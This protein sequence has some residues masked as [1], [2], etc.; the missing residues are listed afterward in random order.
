MAIKEVFFKNKKFELYECSKSVLGL[1]VYN[2]HLANKINSV[3]TQYKDYKFT[4]SDEALFKFSHNE[5]KTILPY[6]KM[7]KKD[8]LKS[9][10][11][12]L[13]VNF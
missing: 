4:A 6:L 11:L 9:N 2:K 1:I 5:V 8:K 10:I 7:R 13:I 12:E 3:I